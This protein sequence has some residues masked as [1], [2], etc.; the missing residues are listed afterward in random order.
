MTVTNGSAIIVR[1]IGTEDNFMGTDLFQLCYNGECGESFIRSMHEKGQLYVSLADVIRTLSA[2]NRK[3]ETRASTKLTTLLEAVIKT[4]DPDE[5]KN[6]PVIFEGQTLSEVFLAEPGL[7][8]VL[9]QDTTPAGKN[10]QRWLF[11][12]VLPSIRE[13]GCYPP[14]EKSE[15]SVNKQFANR[16]QDMLNLMVMEIEKREEMEKRVYAV[17][18]KVSSMENLR[19]LTNF[20]NVSQRVLELGLEGISINELWSWCEKI[21]IEQGCEKIPCPTGVNSNSYYPI[22]VVD[23]AIALYQEILAARATK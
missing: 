6:I 8:R 3:L 1:I 23:E 21:R 20:R 18:H 9:A 15:L 2:E 7:Y 16:L 13:F 4:L 22:A 11:H 14:P 12:K 5:F 19:D 10:F 17:E